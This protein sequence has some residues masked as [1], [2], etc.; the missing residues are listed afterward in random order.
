MT[1]TV[2]PDKRSEIMS[3]IRSPSGL[4][5]RALPL[6]VK[7]YGA[8]IQPTPI[9][10]DLKRQPDY[11]DGPTNTAVWI[12]GCFW[13]G[14]PQ[15]Y[16][17]PKTRTDYWQNKIAGNRRRDATACLDALDKGYRVHIIWEHQI[18]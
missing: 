16:R 11:W 6:L 12:H 1:D 13:H 9:L 15:H 18:E 8:H 2:S 7:L 10:A 5:R 4:E 14:C 17:P 3:K